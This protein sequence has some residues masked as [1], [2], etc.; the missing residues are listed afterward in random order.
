[1]NTKNR[2]G[3]L[4]RQWEDVAL[5]AAHAASKMRA[6]GRMLNGVYGPPRGGVCLAVLFSHLLKIEYLSEP[7]EGCLICDD[8]ADTG[9][10]LLAYKDIPGVTMY[11][12]VAKETAKVQPDYCGMFLSEGDTGISAWIEF[13]WEAPER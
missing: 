10:T 12:D 5:A 13:P 1:M 2:Q 8:I 9:N 7:R 6:D 11:T 4:Q 3:I